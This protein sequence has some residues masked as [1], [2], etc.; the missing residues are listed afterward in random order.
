MSGNKNIILNIQSRLDSRKV[1][2][3]LNE[4]KSVKNSRAIY[5]KKGTGKLYIAKN[6]KQIEYM[7]MIKDVFSIQQYVNKYEP[8][9]PVNMHIVY[10]FKNR[11]RRD[12]PNITQ[13]ILDALV[14]VGVLKDD[15]YNHVIPV[16]YKPFIGK[17][18]VYIS[19]EHLD[20]NNFYNFVS[21]MQ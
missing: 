9:V 8:P 15:D 21:S 20:L 3:L 13:G 14:D 18:F 6:K 7:K 1:F 2:F 16:Y 17:S 19:F 4:A 11:Y 5:K 10:G 12:F